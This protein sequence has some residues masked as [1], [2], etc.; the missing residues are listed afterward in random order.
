M[1]KRLNYLVAAAAVV[2]ASVI[3]QPAYADVEG[4]PLPVTETVLTTTGSGATVSTT[5]ES[6]ITVSTQTAADLKDTLNNRIQDFDVD[7][8]TTDSDILDDLK[9]LVDN[10][11]LTLKLDGFVLTK[12]TTAKVGSAIGTIVIT[13]ASNSNKQTSI[14]FNVEVSLAK[15]ASELKAAIR[16]DIHYLDTDNNMTNS[17]ILD[18][19]IYLID[20]KDL[21][22]RIDNLVITPATT[23]TVSSVTGTVVIIDTA[24]ANKETSL[25]FS[26]II[27]KVTSN[28]SSGGSSSGGGS[29]HSGSGGGSSSSS[30]SSSDTTTSK[31]TSTTNDSATTAKVKSILTSDGT[32]AVTKESI[33]KAISTIGLNNVVDTET[34]KEITKEVAKVVT[35][36]VV[37]NLTTVVGKGVIA[38]EAKEVTAA[39]GNKIA[40]TTLTKDGKCEGAVITTEKASA[41]ATIPVDKATGEVKAV[42]KFVPLLGKYIQLT[43]GVTIGADAVTLPTQANAVYY[44]ATETIAATETVTQGWAKVDNNWYMVNATGD[45][46]TG[47]Q[48]DSTGSWTYLAPESGVMQTGWLKT[49]DTWYHLG[50]NGYMSTGWLKTGDTWYY[51]NSDGSMAANT[52]I[53]G[54]KLDSSG[55]WIR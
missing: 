25:A 4:I 18:E 1:S 13:D 21:K 51:L 55:A 47:W 22:L 8:N 40:V 23:T 5:R 6:A 39:D 46:Q 28:N 35:Q 38:S 52:T 45:S 15:T 41:I 37:S 42:Y 17:Y 26:E 33:S 3:G 19:L 34:A 44:A 27:S 20:N 43:E 36:N 54:Y 49:G 9:K 12:S 11:D 29:K 10:T 48:K 30:S 14:S 53:D 32:A 31:S 24:N 50:G 16:D 2:S 7:N